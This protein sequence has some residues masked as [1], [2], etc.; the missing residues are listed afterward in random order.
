M[1]L[2]IEDWKP[3]KR[4][5]RELERSLE[6]QH[7]QHFWTIVNNPKLK[8]SMIL[9]RQSHYSPVKHMVAEAYSDKPSEVPFQLTGRRPTVSD[10]PADSLAALHA[11][12]KWSVISLVP[13]GAQLL[14]LALASALQLHGSHRE[15]PVCQPRHRLSC[16]FPCSPPTHLIRLT[17]TYRRTA[18][19]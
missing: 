12:H 3:E 18:L 7:H 10:E 8:C 19:E 1:S 13:S 4:N 9:W 15:A 2:K 11:S 5:C 14:A 17:H 6:E 16:A